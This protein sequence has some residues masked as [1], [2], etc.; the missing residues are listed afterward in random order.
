MGEKGVDKEGEL[1][2][3]S[4]IVWERVWTHDRSPILFT[5]VNSSLEK[6]FK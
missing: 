4:D 5:E 6:L 2:R 1:I 3:V